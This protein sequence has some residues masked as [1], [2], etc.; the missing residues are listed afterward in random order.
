MWVKTAKCSNIFKVKW[1]LQSFQWHLYI[2]LLFK[3]YIFLK[4]IFLVWNLGIFNYEKNQEWIHA[5]SGQIRI[6][7]FISI[8]FI[9]A[10]TKKNI[11]L[12]IWKRF[13]ELGK[14]LIFFFFSPR[15]VN[16]SEQFVI[17]LH[18]TK[19]H[20]DILPLYPLLFS[21]PPHFWGM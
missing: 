5:K 1:N 9:I 21:P 8:H 11:F 19:A 10:W 4:S 2:H 12:N 14:W 17:F 3:I 7:F 20:R 13:C 6:S 15:I 16:I 18:Q